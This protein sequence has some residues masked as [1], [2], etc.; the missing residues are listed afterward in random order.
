MLSRIAAVVLVGLSICVLSAEAQVGKKGTKKDEPSGSIEI[1]K[2]KEG[3][4]RYRIKNAEGKT[5]AMPL[6]QMSWEKKADVLKA[7]S[8][9]KI[10]LETA[11]PV[12][13]KNEEPKTEKTEKTTEE[14]K[15]KS[16]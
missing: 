14:K 10:L 2:N 1:Y 11:T 15:K 12:E 6:P 3:E 9:L 5:I 4:Y 13:V 7:I 8:D 16:Q